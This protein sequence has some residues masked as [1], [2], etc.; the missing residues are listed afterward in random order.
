MK[1]DLKR[2]SGYRIRFNEPAKQV[3]AWGNLKTS[4]QTLLPMFQAALTEPYFV[5]DSLRQQD[6]LSLIMFAL[7]DGEIFVCLADGELVGIC[8]FRDIKHER[9]AI[10]DGWA[11]PE[12]RKPENKHKVHALFREMMDYAFN[13]F[14][15][16]GLGLKKVKCDIAVANIPA[17][18][19]TQALGFQQ[20]GLSPLDAF[21]NGELHDSVLLEL[22]NP[23]FFGSAVEDIK[24]H[25]FRRGI[26]QGATGTAVHT[27]GTGA[28]ICGTT[29]PELSS[30]SSIERET[31]DPTG[32]LPGGIH[33]D[34]QAGESSGTGPS[35]G[36]SKAR[37]RSLKPRS[38]GPLRE[39]L[40]S[41]QHQSAD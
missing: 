5:D 14:G 7:R 9:S 21:H 27:D 2:F 23:E 15:P 20:V 3:Y 29:G 12:M 26:E 4:A 6:P 32:E 37:Q 40:L 35:P 25:E 1:T 18:V 31:S 17:L 39:L 41:E 30:T 16:D 8:S 24:P 11:T 10:Y 38:R 28:V 34:E 36:K 19:T 33:D 13:D 22:L